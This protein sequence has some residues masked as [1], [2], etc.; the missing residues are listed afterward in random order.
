MIKDL[1]WLKEEIR[2]DA[3]MYPVY[4]DP[5]DGLLKKMV[6]MHDIL[7]LVN[8]VEEQDKVNKADLDMK[9]DIKFLADSL[10]RSTEITSE[11]NKQLDKLYSA[12]FSAELDI[13][14]D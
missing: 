8:E 4:H 11:L 13:S 2:N 10:K 14:N 3:Y 9:E 6:S 5:Q 12:E 1:N 7:D